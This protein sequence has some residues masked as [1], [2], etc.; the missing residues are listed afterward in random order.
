MYVEI[1]LVLAE[2][3]KEKEV[4]VRKCNRIWV[5]KELFLVTLYKYSHEYTLQFEAVTF[6]QNIFA[7]QKMLVSRMNCLM[8]C[9]L[10]KRAKQDKHYS[11]F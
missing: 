1:D 5:G 8:L 10:T 3:A 11:L 2:V 4:N 6:V 7:A 9:N